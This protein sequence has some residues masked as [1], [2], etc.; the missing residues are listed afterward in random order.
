MLSKSAEEKILS[1]WDQIKDAFA[2]SITGMFP[3]SGRKNTLELVN[4]SYDDSKTKDADIKSQQLAKEQEKTWGV[5]VFA[6]FVLKD[7][8]TGAVINKSKQK[9]AVLPKMTQRFTYIIGGGEYNS[10]YQQRIKSGIYSK[11]NEK[12]EHLTEINLNG[13]NNAFVKEARLKIPF[14]LETKKFKFNYATNNIP[15]YSFLKCVGV[16][17]EEMKKEWGEDV[18]KANHTN[19]WQDDIKKMYEKKWKGRGLKVEGDSFEHLQTAVT[20]ALSRAAVLPETTKLTIG[21]PVEKL[22]GKEILEASAHLLKTARGERAPDDQASMVFKQLLGLDDFI[23]EKFNSPKTG[24]ALKLKI[25]NNVDRKDKISSIV[26]SDLFNRP[27]AQVFYS[28]ALSQRPDQTNPL[29]I[30]ASKSLVTSM[31]PGGITS[32]H[33][34]RP[35][36]KMVNQTHFGVID[37]IMTPEEK[38][39]E[40]LYTYRLVSEK[41]VGKRKYTFMILM[42]R[43]IY[44]RIQQRFTAS[45]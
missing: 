1:Q 7:K 28:N 5:P 8:E 9:I 32:E 26:S 3:I 16:S 42:K 43:S 18:W 15:L 38:L 45:G 33:Q 17:D 31:G 12:G 39:Q 19:K 10:A 27:L 24:Q 41:L 44:I 37:P 20:D 11:I 40:F 29:D 4:L 25:R 23:A 34:L 22:S 21:R 35:S 14:D 6:E 2:S 13:R 30:L 36:M